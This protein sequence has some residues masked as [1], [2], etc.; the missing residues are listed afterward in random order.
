MLD[1][2]CSLPCGEEHRQGQGATRTHA[3]TH[4]HTHTRPASTLARDRNGTGAADARRGEAANLIHTTTQADFHAYTHTHPHLSILRS[5]LLVTVTLHCQLLDTKTCVSE[6]RRP[7]YLPPRFCPGL[8]P[9]PTSPIPASSTS[10]L[11]RHSI[12]PSIYLSP[13]TLASSSYS[14]SNLSTHRFITCVE[15]ITEPTRHHQPLIHAP[16]PL[17]AARKR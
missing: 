17:S 12:T 5:P 10:R 13:P 14:I 11:L 4:T 15:T 6:G 9:S 16:N 1:G 7:P 8:L 3:H 2:W